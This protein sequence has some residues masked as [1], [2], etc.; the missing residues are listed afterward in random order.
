MGWARMVEGDHL[1][2]LEV[3]LA[4]SGALS[5]PLTFT[6]RLARPRCQGKPKTKSTYKPFGAQLVV[7]YIYK[8]TKQLEFSTRVGTIAHR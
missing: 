8:C 2:T 4:S 7:S 5:P 1:E 6:C 3:V